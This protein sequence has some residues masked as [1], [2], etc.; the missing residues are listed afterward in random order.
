MPKK[1]KICPFKSYYM[2]TLMY[3]AEIW[4]WTMADTSRVTAVEMKFLRSIRRKTKWDRSE[5]KNISENLK[6][7]KAN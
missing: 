3:G 5:I 2:P 4:T 6:I 1:E 7:W